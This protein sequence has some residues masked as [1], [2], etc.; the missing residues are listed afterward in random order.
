MSEPADD[1]GLRHEVARLLQAVGFELDDT[2]LQR[3]GGPGLMGRVIRASTADGLKVAAKLPSDD[4]QNDAVAK[5]FG[6]YRR[7]AVFYRELADLLSGLV[8]SCVGVVD[9]PDGSASVVLEDRSDLHTADQLEGA[10]PEQARQAVELLALIHSRTWGHPRLVATELPNP[11]DEQVA[12]FG[13]LFA[14]TWPGFV[15]A[16]ADLID[17]EIERKAHALMDGYDDACRQLAA[18]PTCLV[19]GDFRLDNLLFAEDRAM[20]VDWQLASIGAG[21]YDLC[22][23]LCGSLQP[24]AHDHL[25][26]QL[27]DL[28]WDRLVAGGVT[29]YPRDR[30]AADLRAAFVT[31]LP[32]PVTVAVGVASVDDRAVRLKRVLAERLC[33]AIRRQDLP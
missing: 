27:I 18:P 10:A 26:P 17:A 28:Y 13:P 5:A 16:F 6:Y 3:L 31:Y 11:L 19:H 8:P 30:L 32:I 21:A 22:R 4:D 20:V 25:A 7:E 24:P 33:A 15:T 14:L 9:N 2:P 23:F 29:D 12:G 1:P